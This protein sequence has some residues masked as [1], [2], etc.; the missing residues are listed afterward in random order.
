[1]GDYE[2]VN[3]DPTQIRF[4]KGNKKIKGGNKC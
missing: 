4:K 2:V 3:E 1:M